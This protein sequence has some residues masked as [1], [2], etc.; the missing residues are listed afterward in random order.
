[1]FTK[2]SSSSS[3]KGRSPKKAFFESLSLDG[4]KDYLLCPHSAVGF[5][6]ALNFKKANPENTAVIVSLATAHIG[7]FVDSILTTCDLEAQPDFRIALENSIPYELA[8]LKKIVNKRV[9]LA[10]NTQT[11]ADFVVDRFG[12]RR[13]LITSKSLIIFGVLTA[14][15]AVGVYFMTKRKI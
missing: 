9:I 13:S 14:S 11:V 15:L 10:N 3:P 6:A 5:K 4:L 1:V 8:R 12:G 7:K 2:T